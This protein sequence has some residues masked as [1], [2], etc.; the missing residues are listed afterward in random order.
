[1]ASGARTLGVVGVD[2][3][4]LLP[5]GIA[6]HFAD[7]VANFVVIAING[8]FELETDVISQRIGGKILDD[9]PRRC[10]MRECGDR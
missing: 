10:S 1:M 3:E 6:I 5:K 2:T 7:V 4:A 9:Q 8:V